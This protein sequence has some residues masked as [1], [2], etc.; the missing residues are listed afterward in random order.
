MW[1]FWA[2]YIKARN[3]HLLRIFN[4]ELHLI[5]NKFLVR[6]RYFVDFN[7][8]EYCLFS[9]YKVCSCI[10]RNIFIILTMYNKWSRVKDESLFCEEIHKLL[11]NSSQTGF[12]SQCD[13]KQTGQSSMTEMLENLK[14]RSKH[15]HSTNDPYNRF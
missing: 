3:T 13:T 5:Q 11:Q 2:G 1:C 10:R 8:G 9:K 15:D 12:L 6:W 14:I 7:V 4:N